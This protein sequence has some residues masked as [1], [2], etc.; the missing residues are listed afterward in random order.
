M[1]DIIRP[2][3]PRRRQRHA[4]LAT[5][6]APAF[7]AVLILGLASGPIAAQTVTGDEGRGRAPLTE[8][9]FTIPDQGGDWSK[10]TLPHSWNA[11]DGDDGGD[12]YFRGEG[13][14]R[15]SFDV[16]EG[17]GDR[18][19]F[20]HVGAANEIAEVFVNG[21]S[22]G[23]HEGGYS[24]FRFD[25]TD[26]MVA[27][28]N[29]VEIT[30]SNAAH[31]LPPIVA[32]F[33]FFGGLYRDVSL[34]DVAPT[35]IDL[36]D[37][38]GPG[39]YLDTREITP[40]EARIAARVKLANAGA[41][42]QVLDLEVA[43]R[44]DTGHTVTTQTTRL[45]LPAGARQDR[46]LDLTVPDPR[47]WQGRDDP[48]LY[49]VVTTLRDEAGALLDEVTEPLGI[50]EIAI[51]PQQGFVLNGQP[52]PLRGVSYHQD[53]EE[54]GFAATQ[55]QKERDFA[56]MD[57]LGANSVRLAHYQHSR[58]VYD[59]ADRHGMVTWAEIPVISRVEM[60][61][62]Y[63]DNARQ[64]MRELI[65]QN[66]NHPSIAVWGV[67]NE[68]AL[69]S[70]GDVTPLLRDLD[71]IAR[72]EDPGRLTTA[73]VL[74][75][76]TSDNPLMQITQT[77]GQNLYFGWYYGNPTADLG[78][79]L[80]TLHASAPGLPI[81]VSEY[82]AGA[83]ASIQ[84]ET[85]VN[86]D[87]S[88]QYQAMFHEEA[89]LQMIARPWL[90]STYVWAM[91]DFASDG[92]DEGEGPGIND[93]GLVSRD[94]QDRK[95][96]FYW[97]QAHWSDQPVLHLTGKRL[98]D[99]KRGDVAVRAYTNLPE[100]ELFLN[101]TSQGVVEA[102]GSRRLIWNVELAPGTNT[103]ELVASADGDTLRDSAEWT[104]SVNDDT[105]LTSQLV[106]V[107]AI[108]D[109]V[110]NLPYGTTPEALPDLLRLPFGA[111]FDTGDRSPD[112]VLNVGDS[113]EVVAQ[114]GDRRSYRIETGPISVARRVQANREGGGR[115]LPFGPARLAVD[116]QD[117]FATDPGDGGYWHSGDVL[118]IPAWIKVD[119]GAEYYIDTLETAWMDPAT[120]A[121]GSGL[122]TYHVDIA[123]EE[124]R[125]FAVFNETYEPALPSRQS[126]ASGH[127]SDRIGR[128]ARYLRV[129]ITASDF[130]MMRGGSPYQN[131]AI[132]ELSVLGGLIHSDEVQID[133]RDRTI[134]A[135]GRSAEEV[136]ALLN[137]AA[138]DDRIDVQDGAIIVSA[139]DNL[140]RERYELI[141]E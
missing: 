57:E 42:D 35:H 73:A 79:W 95:D 4:A 101:G 60:T 24:A 6:L 59:L 11:V 9:E 75:R 2:G 141:A 8:W 26:A 100:A 84:S 122:M 111:S 87:H 55:A 45:T 112:A 137:T 7:C 108:G 36:G 89:Y 31:G 123:P 106:S 120:S 125:S 121:E 69:Q 82:G 23:T 97:Y 66:Y 40:T 48:Y 86:Q 136:A 65:R 76:L 47:L 3:F 58:S 28:R 78:D 43:L 98:T 39:V 104:L 131:K 21:R 12:N 135:G 32:D 90:W 25:I 139:S 103:L 140:R 34:I 88:E 105:L 61:D 54:N 64:Q 67:W 17:L 130:Y 114:N 13:R 56:I 127:T 119:L 107:D 52:M 72:E 71:R 10:V 116:G 38:G 94:R 118:R 124:T 85:P 91:F 109:R 81:G 133:Y 63:S 77:V 138:K 44:D 96:A 37:H 83:G 110:L 30:V 51:D 70:Q 18:R 74:G 16:A 29:E 134:A 20:I 99:R 5:R 117:S 68:V 50:R 15:T 102:T 22:V 49:S 1:T 33:T 93:K 53:V 129:T 14:Y 132:T 19:V 80:D 62:A 92:R 126:D 115:G 128:V 41:A 113:F 46:Q 27:G